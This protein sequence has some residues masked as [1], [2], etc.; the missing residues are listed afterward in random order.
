MPTLTLGGSSLRCRPSLGAGQLMKLA[1][2]MRG[3]EEAQLAG[4]YDF[5][6]LIVVAD[7]R[8]LLDAALDADDLDFDMLN[9]AIGDL[10]VEYQEEHPARPTK[11]SSPSP[12]SPTPPGGTS[13][14]DSSP[15]D[16]ARVV[17]L[18]SRGG[19]SAA[20]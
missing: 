11:R 6:H 15:P 13:R 17:S 8:P 1:K 5:L 4:M 16:T 10:M 12:S 18:S 7:D 20:S 3:D 2:A 9:H 19:R 14:A